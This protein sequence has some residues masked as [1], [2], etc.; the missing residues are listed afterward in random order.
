M[1]G[2]RC[3]CS[4]QANVDSCRMDMFPQPWLS[5]PSPQGPRFFFLRQMQHIY[6]LP[7][8]FS[9]FFCLRYAVFRPKTHPFGRSQRWFPLARSLAVDLA[10]WLGK[11]VR[12]K[13]G[14]HVYLATRAI[15]RAWRL[16]LTQEHSRAR[17]YQIPI[18]PETYRLIT[19]WCVTAK[20]I[21]QWRNG[22]VE[23]TA[24]V[25]F[26]LE[27]PGREAYLCWSLVHLRCDKSRAWIILHRE[28]SYGRGN[29]VLNLF[30]TQI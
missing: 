3:I 16:F 10:S 28:L 15:M 1:E 7:A 23:R 2:W 19:W 22:F 26:V 6:L 13:L 20:H 29:I 4:G 21:L 25:F 30:W 14:C 24:S 27:T 8:C 17:Q 12:R 18:D 5:T 11:M 9:N